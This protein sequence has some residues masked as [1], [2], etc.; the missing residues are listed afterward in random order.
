[1]NLVAQC[2]TIDEKLT[3]MSARVC[4]PLKVDA[5]YVHSLVLQLELRVSAQER[6]TKELKE[7]L[8][9]KDDL[10]KTLQEAL[11]HSET[12]PDAEVTVHTDTFRD[13]TNFEIASLKGEV[14]KLKEVKDVTTPGAADILTELGA[15]TAFIAH[16]RRELP[17][18]SDG[19][20]LTEQKIEKIT[21]DLQ[22]YISRM[23][24]YQ[25]DLVL[26]IQAENRKRF[27]EAERLEQYSRKDCVLV[28]GV[29]YKHGENTTNTVCDIAKAIG[30]CISPTDISVSHRTGKQ[31]GNQP[32]P[33]ICKFARRETKY[34]L[35]SNRKQTRHIKTDPEGRPVQIFIDE[36]LTT[37]RARVCHK[38]RGDKVPHHVKDGKIFITPSDAEWKVLDTPSD[39]EALD[40]PDRTKVALGIFPRD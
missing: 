26:D 22:S 20:A 30:V 15:D 13:A 28:K 12:A 23:E 8:T 40:W 29:P 1:L 16:A 38:L 5:S 37:M 39:F 9:R 10:I 14:A 27:M 17:L 7:K 36:N 6:E 32:R 4:S 31:F 21:G 18:L 2:N 19:C 11:T 34:L 3:T 24:V 33:I 35:L 25:H